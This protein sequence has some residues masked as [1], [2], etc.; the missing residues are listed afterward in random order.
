[1]QTHA[2]ATCRLYHVQVSHLR[3]NLCVWKYRR[4]ESKCLCSVQL[5]RRI[6]ILEQKWTRE[7]EL[8]RVFL[9]QLIK[10]IRISDVLY[11]YLQVVLAPCSI[12]WVK[13][14]VCKSLLEFCIIRAGG[15]QRCPNGT[16][17]V[18]KPPHWGSLALRFLWMMKTQNV[19][20][21]KGQILNI[22]EQEK[23]VSWQS[24]EVS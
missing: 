1:M 8:F 13:N 16:E 21:K 3:R 23:A 19:K 22:S 2:H 5:K 11:W 20:L 12:N 10:N 18:K 17:T 9:F 24:A 15:L 4:T 7:C 14:C 6:K